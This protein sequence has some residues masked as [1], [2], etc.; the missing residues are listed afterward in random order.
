MTTDDGKDAQSLTRAQ[1]SMLHRYRLLF[2]EAPDPYLVTDSDGVIQEA[3]AAARDLLGGDTDLLDT[4]LVNYVVSE[5][6]AQFEAWLER[7]H[8]GAPDARWDTVLD[9]GTG[10][11]MPVEISLADD[12]EEIG[13]RWVLRDQRE[14]VAAEDH[15]RRVAENEHLAASELRTDARAKNSF[16]VSLSHDLRGPIG[17]LVHQSE[18]LNVPDL[19]DE[20]RQRSQVALL[21]NAALLAQLLDALVEI[22]RFALGEL[23]LHRRPTPV[24]EVVHHL[25]DTE[26][27]S[28]Q[29]VL[30]DED[31]MADVDADA[32]RR[33]LRTVANTVG[34]RSD[35][36]PVIVEVLDRDH[37]VIVTISAT[38][39][40]PGSTSFE[41]RVDT[42]LARLLIELHGGE[43]GVR[44]TDDGHAV[45]V[46][47]PIP[48]DGDRTA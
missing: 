43:L 34:A 38:T 31:V 12:L 23:Q 13:Y 47:L 6:R 41:D 4:K 16:I 48:G 20:V 19:S 8:R 30:P 14:R 27:Q 29:V 36:A 26:D 35:G 1:M 15:L 46:S 28:I 3:N 39:V 42:R 9:V 40:I 18:L 33:A 37:E 25:V 24:S 21:Q 17:A 10:D 2:E 32:V 11:G 45:T 44:Q 5:H 7:I 22:E